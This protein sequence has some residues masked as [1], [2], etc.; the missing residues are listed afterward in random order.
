MKSGLRVTSLFLV[1]VTL[2]KFTIVTANMD[3]KE[4]RADRDM[5]ESAQS[6]CQAGEE[7]E[8]LSEESA[9]DGFLRRSDVVF[10]NGGVKHPLP[11]NRARK[12]L[13]K[14]ALSR[15]ELRFFIESARP[16]MLGRVYTLLESFLALK[17]AEGSVVERRLY[18]GMSVPDLISRL[19]RKR[20][21]VFFTDADTWMLRNS[22]MGSD[23]FT[24]VGTDYETAPLT[25]NDVL[26]Y[27]EM[28]LSALMG[29][30]SFTK[31]F[32]D[33]NRFNCGK[34]DKV[35]SF[36]ETG[37]II[38]QVGARFERSNLMEWQH[39]IVTRSQN[40][41]TNGYGG[42]FDGHQHS[43]LLQCWADLYRTSHLP[44]FEEAAA[45]P[46]RFER[47]DN[48]TYFDKHTYGERVKIWAHTLL[49]EANERAQT[50]GK[51]AYVH[52][53]G[54]GLGVWEIHYLQEKIFLTQFIATAES[55]SIQHVSDIDFSYCGPVQASRKLANGVLVHH[56]KRNP[57]KLLHGTGRLLVANYAWDSNAWPGN[58]FYL[59]ALSASGDPAAA[60]CSMI[61]ELH[62]ADINSFVAG[63]HAVRY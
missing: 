9:L 2:Y 11:G 5:I 7:D 1:S 6:Y 49:A 39:M 17:V 18:H 60:A 61:S 38:G 28:A 27:D 63:S 14:G 29:L 53:V 15:D 24:N 26:S 31:F 55:L 48:N 45:S 46:E 40:T 22:K 25:L 10:G 59:N 33:G 37:V 41:R 19:F 13:E 47:L 57:Q 56:S 8:S 54:L 12:L 32:N 35:G 36:E 16:V 3:W 58:E 62:N 23:G 50:A 34:A 42:A 44:L 20:V 51:R 52:V 30:S 4:C 21:P 43:Q